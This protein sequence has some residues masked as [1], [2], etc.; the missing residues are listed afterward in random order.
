MSGP[1]RAALCAMLLLLLACGTLQI[2][3]EG[4]PTADLAAT[5]TVGALQAQNVQLQTQVA[6]L[7]SASGGAA[8]LI[9]PT[10][11]AGSGTASTKVPPAASRITFLNG[12][13]VG[14]VNAPIESGATQSFVLQV[15]EGQPMY[16]YVGSPSSDVTLSINRQDGTP[17]LGEAAHQISWQG[18]MPQTEN[19]YI[20]VHGGT[21]TEQYSLAVTV[22]SRIQF[23]QGENTATVSGKTVGGYGVSYALVAGKGQKM[24]VQLESVSAPASLSILGFTDGQQYLASS[25]SQTSYGFV[26]A[27]T[28]DYIIVVVPR[29]GRV[30]NYTLTVDVQ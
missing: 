24:S 10:Q 18:T 9:S 27:A 8:T 17:I 12:A 29:A 3:L 22:P 20:T 16:V 28:Q 4:V 19:Y 5:G 15:F 13:T 30:V 23:Q 14:V 2:G 6:R 21:T 7:S 26:L 25:S 11:P 1:V